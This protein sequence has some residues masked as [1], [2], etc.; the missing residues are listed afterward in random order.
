[1]IGALAGGGKPP[2]AP[3]ATAVHGAFG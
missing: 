2:L 3:S 1:M